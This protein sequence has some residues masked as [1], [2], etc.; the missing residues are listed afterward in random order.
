[1]YKIALLV[2][3]LAVLFAPG[4]LILAQETGSSTEPVNSTFELPT[5]PLDGLIKEWFGGSLKDAAQEGMNKV[6]SGLEDAAG[7]A[8]DSAQEAL[9]AELER[10]ANQAVQSAREKA[11]GYVGGVV[12]IV[13]TSVNNLISKIKLFFT[14][15]FKKPSPTI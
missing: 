14:D 10:Q 4:G 7:Q 12:A 15:L 2:A 1:M 5:S 3:V 9:K 8:V 11:E 6:Q 13:K